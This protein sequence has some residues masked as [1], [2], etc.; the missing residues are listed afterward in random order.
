MRARLFFLNFCAQACFGCKS[1][2][3][4]CSFIPVLCSIRFRF[5]Q[6]IFENLKEFVVTRFHEV[7]EFA[8]AVWGFGNDARCYFVSGC[9][10]GLLCAVL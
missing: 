8:C 10:A 1:T 5:S 9:I 7:E 4:T 2:V 6:A 3:G